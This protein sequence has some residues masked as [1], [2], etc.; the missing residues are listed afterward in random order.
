M[1]QKRKNALQDAENLQGSLEKTIKF[2]RHPLAKKGMNGEITLK[3]AAIH[4]HLTEIKGFSP[5]CI[6]KIIN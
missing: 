5:A 3:G 6:Q 2:E 1:N 4:I